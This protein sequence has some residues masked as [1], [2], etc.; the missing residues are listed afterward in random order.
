MKGRLDAEPADDFAWFLGGLIPERSN[1]F[2]LNATEELSS[3]AIA[4]TAIT[5]DLNVSN[6][7]ININLYKG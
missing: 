3:G 4:P 1:D 2:P 6:C 7:T 5:V